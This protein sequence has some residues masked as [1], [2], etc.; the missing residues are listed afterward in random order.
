MA[1]LK[2]ICVYCGSS[3]GSRPEYRKTAE[4]LGCYLAT[5]NIGLVF[6]GSDLGLMGMLADSV[7]AAGGEAIGV[8]PKALMAREIAHTGLTELRVVGTM[9][10]RKALMSELSDAFI[11]LPGG[12]GTM[13]ELIEMLTW[14]QLGI[15]KKPC[16]V[17]N[18]HG[19]F[20][21]LME[22]LDHA[23]EEGFLRSENRG[24]LL[25]DTTVESLFRRIRSFSPVMV[26][27]W[28][29]REIR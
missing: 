15:H 1:D 12:Y 25:V 18:I 27:K 11:A 19:Y 6:G 29:G 16:A 7:L 22:F 2:R 24:L 3:T 14:S 17:L 21:G 13:E 20:D 9:H 8:I 26:E 10:A 28:I 23:V 4:E 5:N